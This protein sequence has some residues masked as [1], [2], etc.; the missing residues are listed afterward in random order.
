V[1]DQSPTELLHCPAFIA[2]FARLR[3]GSDLTWTE[4]FRAA[5]NNHYE[6]QI[7]PMNTV[8]PIPGPHAPVGRSGQSPIVGTRDGSDGQGGPNARQ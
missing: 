7:E 3:A 1:P 5:A 8:L 2:E 4:C 6:V